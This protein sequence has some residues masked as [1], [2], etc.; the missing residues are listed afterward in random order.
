VAMAVASGTVRR[1]PRDCAD[2][3]IN[4]SCH[5]FITLVNTCRCQRDVD[6]DPHFR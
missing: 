3:P 4:F 2:G 6:A 5:R 1:K